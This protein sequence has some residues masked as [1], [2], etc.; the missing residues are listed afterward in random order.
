MPKVNDPNQF[1]YTLEI[2]HQV[3][4]AYYAA[5]LFQNF[6]KCLVLGLIQKLFKHKWIKNEKCTVHTTVRRSKRKTLIRGYLET[7]NRRSVQDTLI[8]KKEKLKS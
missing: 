8:M 7:Q 1:K 6:W 4:A 3:D 5:F 2:C